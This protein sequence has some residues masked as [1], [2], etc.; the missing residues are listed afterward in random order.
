MQT[1]IDNFTR[2]T[3]TFSN[4][5]HPGLSEFAICAIPD[6]DRL[7][8]PS[9]MR[10]DSFFATAAAAFWFSIDSQDVATSDFKAVL[11]CF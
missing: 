7:A 4:S 5:N 11:F 8:T 2:L 6:A 3:Y 1:G 10:S 9:I